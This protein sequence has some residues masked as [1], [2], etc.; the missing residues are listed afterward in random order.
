VHGAQRRAGAEG[1]R[2]TGAQLSMH[3]AITL[4]PIGFVRGGR[5][6]PVDDDWD[7]V[8][9]AIELDPAQFKADATASLG[10]FSHVEVVYHF[11]RVPDDEIKGGARHPRGR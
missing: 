8:A 7:R 11:N 6:E 3:D 2:N 4:R 1:A 10:D 9:A 5:A